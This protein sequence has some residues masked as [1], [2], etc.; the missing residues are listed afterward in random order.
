MLLDYFDTYYA[1][2]PFCVLSSLNLIMVPYMQYYERVA[3][4]DF[5][6]APLYLI[7]LQFAINFI[8]LIELSLTFYALGKLVHG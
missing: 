2:V 6:I 1:G 5:Y 7:G 3:P 8:Y 4:V